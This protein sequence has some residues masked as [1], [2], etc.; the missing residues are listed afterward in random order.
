LTGIF[1]F[2]VQIKINAV[3]SGPGEAGSRI[4]VNKLKR[5]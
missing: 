1:V 5:G 4:I 3:G 2:L